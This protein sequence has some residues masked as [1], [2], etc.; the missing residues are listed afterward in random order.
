M[1][2]ICKARVLLSF[3][4]YFLSGFCQARVSFSF[5]S[6]R[7]GDLIIKNLIVKTLTT[8]IVTT[9]GKEFALHI[10][11]SF[12]M[13]PFINKTVDILIPESIEARTVNVREVID[14]FR[15][16]VDDYTSFF[17]AIVFMAP[18]RFRVTFKSARKME[19]AKNS[20][21]VVRGFPV[22][23]KSVSPYKWVNITR[24]S[25]GIPEVAIQEVLSPYGKIRLVKSEVY[26]NIYTGV[27][28]V[29]MEITKDIP[30]RVNIAGHWCFVHYRGQKRTCF[31]CGE[32]GHQRDKCPRKKTSAQPVV[33]EAPVSNTMSSTNINFPRTEVVQPMEAVQTTV[34]PDVVSSSD[35]LPNVEEV[36]NDPPDRTIIAP[37]IEGLLAAVSAVESND[38]PVDTVVTPVDK[39]N[40]RPQTRSKSKKSGQRER[41]RSR[42]PVDRRPDTPAEVSSP[43]INESRQLADDTV[44][45]AFNQVVRSPDAMH[46]PDDITSQTPLI[47]LPS[48]T[49]DEDAGSVSDASLGLSLGD[50]STLEDVLDRYKDCLNTDTPLTQFAPNLPCPTQDR[51]VFD[52]GPENTLLSDESFIVTRFSGN[53]SSHEEDEED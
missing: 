15:G 52:N 36:S 14:E 47:D 46:G 2:W 42:S 6:P 30:T 50:V 34:P 10:C 18:G 40:D 8:L 31:E 24:L 16:Q 44:P 49:S 39:E 7:I 45:P 43:E 41:S 3:L 19:I 21:L 25:Y 29:L 13:I 53:I 1:V 48:I 5:F 37:V 22:E 17:E 9:F 28:Q 51:V 23:F 38:P 32:E 20:G 11:T 4:L 33:V 12:K 35:T 26:S 27:R